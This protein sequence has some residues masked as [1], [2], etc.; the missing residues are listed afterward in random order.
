MT[1]RKTKNT[2]NLINSDLRNDFLSWDEFV[3]DS[4]SRRDRQRLNKL[5]YTNG[6]YYSLTDDLTGFADL[7]NIR[8]ALFDAGKY[9]AES[10][11]PPF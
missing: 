4:L 10:L 11:F 6:W 1:V 8:A 3:I 2:Y 5:I 9:V 7:M